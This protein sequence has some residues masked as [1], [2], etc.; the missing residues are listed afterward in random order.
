[1]KFSSVVARAAVLGAVVLC[2]PSAQAGFVLVSGPGDAAINGTTVNNFGYGEATTANP[3]AKYWSGPVGSETYTS[4]LGGGPVSLL[5]VFSANGT[6]SVYSDSKAGTYDNVEDTQIGI[7]N[8]SGQTLSAVKLTGSAGFFSFDG[9]GISA[10]AGAG[11]GATATGAGAPSNTFDKSTG[12]YGG[13]MTYFSLTQGG[14]SITS[15]SGATSGYANFVNGGLAS[16]KSTYFSLEGDPA[17]L[18]GTSFASP[19]PEPGSVVM[20]AGAVALFGFRRLRARTSAP[21]PAA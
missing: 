19:A 20:V 5:A 12:L 21:K 9:D 2:V 18:S 7:L 6:V 17:G 3:L 15:A 14:S 4:H 1:M 16:G 13:P 10:T 8:L 11:S